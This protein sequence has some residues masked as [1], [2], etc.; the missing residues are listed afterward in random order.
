MS[1]S[2][3]GSVQSGFSFERA[4]ATTRPA[5]TSSTPKTMAPVDQVEISD[6]G[7]LMNQS[8]DNSDVREARLAQI[9]ADIDAGT[10][11]TPEKMEAALM[12]MMG[13]IDIEG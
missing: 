10:Y 8:P 3:P 13:Q 4:K 9:K 5:E 2:G 7:K 11:D 1:I 6:L 12:K